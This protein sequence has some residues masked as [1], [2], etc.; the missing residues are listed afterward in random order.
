MPAFGIEIPS[1]EHPRLLAAALDEARQRGVCI[2]RVSQ[3]SGSRMLT[4]AERTEMLELAHAHDVSVYLFTSSRNSF[5]PLADR[6]GA[7][8]LRG[9]AALADARAELERCAQE[10]VDGVLVADLGLLET[11]GRLRAEGGLGNL[12]LKTSAMMAPYN[13]ATAALY[14]RLGATSI[15]V[16]SASSLVDLRAMRAALSPSTTIDIYV[17]APDDLG[18]GLRYRD[19]P[20]FVTDLAPVLLKLGLRNAQS[21][22]PY[23]GHLGEY[24]E[25]TMREKVRRAQLLLQELERAGIAA[26]DARLPS[27]PGERLEPASAHP[28]AEP[29]PA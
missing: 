20:A 10:G 26:P 14:E 15:N 7:D 5:E 9:E 8:R 27:N 29:S 2:T 22:Y 4:G 17:E 11:A 16:S 3:G 19:A 1:V 18:A 6:L 12:G 25:R 21:L 23:G 24:A 13:A 28:P